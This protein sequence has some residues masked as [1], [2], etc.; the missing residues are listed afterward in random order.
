MN[1]RASSIGRSRL[2]PAGTCGDAAVASDHAV[3]CRSDA[4][5]DNLASRVERRATAVAREHHSVRLE[6]R[7]MGVAERA[8][9]HAA[10]HARLG[11]GE[12]QHSD[13]RPI[14]RGE[15]RGELPTEWVAISEP[16][17]CEV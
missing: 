5:A 2:M 1:S 13:L 16:Q 9:V 8:A 3:Q 15:R 11:V 6:P 17:H 12:W 4:P 10:S 7:T 14:R